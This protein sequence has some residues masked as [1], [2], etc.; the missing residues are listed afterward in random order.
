MTEK[1]SFVIDV[2]IK[3]TEAND[4]QAEKYQV[5][6]KNTSTAAKKTA[7]QEGSPKEV[8]PSEK[9]DRFSVLNK[10]YRRYR[11]SGKLLHSS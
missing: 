6:N 11:K 10:N 3:K 4:R 8:V 9:T 1:G 2:C 7:V 5:V